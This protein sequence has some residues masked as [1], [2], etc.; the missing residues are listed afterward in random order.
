MHLRPATAADAAVCAALYAPYV[1][2]RWTSFEIDPPDEAEMA[3]R[4]AAYSATHA[5]LIAEDADG[6]FLGY[7]YASPHRTREAYKTSVDVAVYVSPA[8]TGRGVGKALYAELFTQLAAKGYH[9]AYAGIAIPNP[10][11]EALHRAVGFTPVGVYKEV[12]WKMGGWRD[13]GWWQRL[14]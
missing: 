10:A 8:A 5:W 7:A 2:D 11:S 4:I 12:G 3:R 9:A 1:T 14:L 13:V 6:T